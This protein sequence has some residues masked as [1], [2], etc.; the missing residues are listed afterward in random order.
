MNDSDHTARNVQKW[1]RRADTYD[2][3]LFNYLRY[4]QR[5]LIARLPLSPHQWVLD[6]GCGT[7]WAVR[8]I[9]ALLEQQ[10]QLFGIDL[11]PKILEKAAAQA[12]D[13]P[14]VHYEQANSEALPFRADSFD[15]IICTNSFHHY[16]RPAQAL[17]EMRRVLKPGGRL[18][19]GDVTA[20]SLLAKT[21]DWSARRREPEHVRFYTTPDYRHLFAE[22]R[23]EYTAVSAGV[24]LFKVHV[25]EK[26]LQ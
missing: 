20:D 6:I 22:A 19:L 14:S 15:L 17:G 16:L 21:L 2:D 11:A 12:R 26:R 13:D 8:R 4:M 25:G 3:Q 1:D 5:R 23:L 24:P 10:G 7:G 18:Y 9:A